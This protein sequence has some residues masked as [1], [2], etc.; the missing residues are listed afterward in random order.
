M[1]DRDISQKI[2]EESHEKVEE[3]LTQMTIEQKVA[4][5]SSV[6]VYELL[7]GLNFDSEKAAQKL[8][9]GIGQITRIGGA[10]NLN[11]VETARLYNQIQSYIINNTDIKIPALVHEEACSGYMARGSTLFPQAIGIASTWDPDIAYSMAEVIRKEMLY[12]GSRQA[13][14]PLL[15]VSRDARWGRM[16][17]TFGEDPYLISQIAIKYISGLQGDFGKNCVIATGKHYAGYGFSDGG[18]NWAP[19]HISER[20]MREIVLRPFEAAVKEAKLGS[21]MPAYHEIDGTPMH[22]SSFLIDEVLRKEW[23]FE[24]TVV[25]DYFA[26]ASLQDYHNLA[27]NRIDSA[28]E[29][30]N[31]G[32]DVELPNSDSYGEPLVEAI[33]SGRVSLEL[34]NK[35]VRRVL[36]QKFRLGLFDES[37][38]AELAFYGESSMKKNEEL[39]HQA[40]RESIILLKNEN[41]ILPLSSDFTGKM[42]IIGPNADSVRNMMG[43]YAY[44]CHIENLIETREK[45]NVFSQPLP[46]DITMDGIIGNYNSV[47]KAVIS[48]AG[49]KNVAYSLGCGINDGNKEEFKKAVEVASKS[50]IAVVVVGDKSGLTM[51]C[52]SG[53]SRDRTTLNLPGMQGDLVEAVISTGV[54]TVVVLINGRPVTGNWIDKASAV[55]EA[56]LPGVHGGEAI[57]EALFGKLNPGGK[58]PVSYPFTV[59]QVPVYY[60]HPPSGGRSQWHGDY[61]DSPSKVRFPFGFGLSYTDFAISD[62]KVKFEYN[63]ENPS[64]SNLMVEVKV[65]NSGKA[66]GDFVVQVYVKTHSSRYTRPEKEL[67]AFKRINLK[68]GGSRKIVFSIPV[69]ILCYYGEKKWHLDMQSLTTMVGKS[70][71]EIE[72]QDNTEV[73]EDIV[74]EKLERFSSEVTVEG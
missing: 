16:E 55:I 53:E 40:A 35:S 2:N 67:K 56:W 48:L 58:L 52:T 71:L 38:N 13:L 29:A 23:G 12:A 73:P 25:S 10:S 5:L 69:D 43:D 24:G 49:E 42:A 66:S 45:N 18:M 72:F 37:H 70:S 20:E 46:S 28:I 27:L 59:G 63:S 61:V 7:D 62:G 32:V 54:P 19:A 33:R 74:I 39:S 11:P 68:K 22:A 9:L 57:A 44:P 26:I 34:L 65:T 1:R 64:L 21:I 36:N 8:S 15:D 60:N 31:A 47:L 51:E 6:W 17:E 50:D 14:A 3:L 30:I 4:Q 41:G